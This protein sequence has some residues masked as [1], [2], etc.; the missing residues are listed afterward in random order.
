MIYA[1]ILWFCIANPVLPVFWWILSY[2]FHPIFD[3]F[4][5]ANVFVFNTDQVK[6]TLFF[7][8]VWHLVPAFHVIN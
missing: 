4:E 6:Y 5:S 2:P 1:F 7:Y 8:L 3:C